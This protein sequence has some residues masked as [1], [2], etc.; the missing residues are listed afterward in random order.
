[1]KVRKSMV[2]YWNMKDKDEKMKN[3]GSKL[4]LRRRA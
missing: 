1:M 4:I 3:L 2:A